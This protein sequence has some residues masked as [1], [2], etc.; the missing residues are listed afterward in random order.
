MFRDDPIEKTVNLSLNETLS[1]TILTS[2]T[3]LLVVLCVLFI[4]SGPIKDFAFALT[5]GLVAGTYS[6]IYVASP[7]FLWLN[8]RIYK[9]KGHLI[10]SD[11]AEAEGTGQL[12]GE[13]GQPPAPEGETEAEAAPGITVPVPA[14]DADEPDD[15]PSGEPR[16]S[17]RRRRPG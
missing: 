2:G 14:A 7:V 3:T 10:G 16:R 13:E 9:G 5:V 6:S 11:A 4:G 1:R 17:R 15:S 12:L 8:D